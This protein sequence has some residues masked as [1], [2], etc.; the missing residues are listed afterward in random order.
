[1]VSLYSETKVTISDKNETVE[2]D[3]FEIDDN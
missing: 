1:M 2:L 3:D